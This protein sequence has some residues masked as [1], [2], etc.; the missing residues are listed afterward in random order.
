MGETPPGL[1]D[2]GAR[3][4]MGRNHKAL[5]KED[6]DLVEGHVVR[7]ARTWDLLPGELVAASGER[8]EAGE[9][10]DGLRRL[11]GAMPRGVDV[12]QSLGVR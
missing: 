9:L 3:P 8:F 6:I 5:S 1:L 2:R 4:L 7:R 12:A 10:A 11:Y